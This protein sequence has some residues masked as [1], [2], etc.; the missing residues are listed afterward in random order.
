[1][2]KNNVVKLTGRDTISDPLTELL[3]TGAERL[4][5]QAVE[6]EL[7]ELLAEHS[8]RRTE[9]GKAGVVRNGHLPG[10]EL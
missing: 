8:E 5:Y 10:R 1:M 3:R 4:I 6:V 2:R 7:L 9:D